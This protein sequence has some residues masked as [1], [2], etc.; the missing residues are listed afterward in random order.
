LTASCTIALFWSI[1]EAR[2]SADLGCICNIT[3]TATIC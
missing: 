3:L 2:H 1:T